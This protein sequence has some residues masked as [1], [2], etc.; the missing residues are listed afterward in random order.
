MTVQNLDSGYNSLRQTQRRSD[1]RR[2]CVI[3][4][5]IYA[6]LGKI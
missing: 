6:A 5:A 2:D 4:N 3:V 1:M